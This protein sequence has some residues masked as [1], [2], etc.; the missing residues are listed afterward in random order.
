MTYDLGFRIRKLP[1]LVLLSS[2]AH[3]PPAASAGPAVT[4]IAGGALH[5]LFTKSDGSLWAMGDNT[6]GQLGL[7]FAPAGTNVPVQVLGSGVGIVAAGERHSLFRMGRDL[8][9]MGNNE[10]GQLGDG[11]STNNHYF[12]EKI[13]SGTSGINGISASVV[14]G[15]LDHSLFATSSSIVGN[16]TL[17]TMGNNDSGQLGDGTNNERNTPQQIASGQ[18]LAVSAGYGFSLFARSDGSLW[19]MGA[20]DSGQLGIGTTE[21]TNTPVKIVSSGVTALAAGGG[22]TL[23]IKSDGSLWG[24]GYNGYGQLGDNTTVDKHTPEQLAFNGV[25][26]VAAGFDHSVYLKSDGSLWGTGDNSYGQLGD[27]TTNRHYVAFQIVPS[28]VVTVAA[29]YFHTLFIKSD[30]SLWGM[31]SNGEGELGV[32]SYTNHLTPFEIVA[33]V[34]PA[35]LI[36]SIIVSRTN[37]ILDAA[38]GVSGEILYTLMGTNLTQPLNQWQPVATNTLSANGNF[39]ITATNAITPNAAQEFFI[40]QAH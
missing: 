37:V 40:L 18:I 12:P 24:M 20:N 21:N 15:G 14:A 17:R 28:N 5:S 11:T 2:F 39:S 35:P 16:N 31:G 19:G 23:F 30:G 6:Y 33:G 22:H 26:A 27:G 36:T 29:G 1:A 13:F 4:G 9:A 25:T 8:W 38:N 10:F 34:P 32:G 3:L 7:G